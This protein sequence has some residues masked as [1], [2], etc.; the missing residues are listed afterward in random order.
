M[1]FIGR[2][3][4]RAKTP[5]CIIVREKETRLFLLRRDEEGRS[6]TQMNA[7]RMGNWIA[8]KER[9]ESKKYRECTLLRKAF[10]LRPADAGLWRTSRRGRPRIDAKT[11]RMTKV[12]VVDVVD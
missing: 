2:Q 7:D 1:K 9:G 10:L 3:S 8:A 5:S 6:K 11:E 12:D 4:N